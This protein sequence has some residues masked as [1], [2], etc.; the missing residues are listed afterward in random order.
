MPTTLR[1]SADPL[2]A[3]ADLLVVCVPAP[4]SLD[5]PAAALDAA[6]DGV[7]A[8]AM[9]D[10]EIDGK[11]GSSAVFHAAAGLGAPR[12]AVVGVG[13]GRAEDWRGAG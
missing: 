8:R 10:G 9:E 11:A 4:P 1:K 12:A 2:A 3:R 7:V 5:G 6:L 13:E